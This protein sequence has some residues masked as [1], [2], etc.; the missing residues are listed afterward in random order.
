MRKLALLLAGALGATSAAITLAP[1][2]ADEG[3]TTKRITVVL[4][5]RDYKVIDLPP[6]GTSHGDVRVGNADLYDVRETRRVGSFHLFCTLTN[7]ADEPGETAELTECLYTYRLPGGEITT[8]GV[9]RRA[10]HGEVATADVDGITGGTRRFRSA[11]G[12]VHLLP[13]QG[14]KRTIVLRLVL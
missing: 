11:R 4:K 3:A 14:D 7:P 8:Q 5:N 10:S 6:A 2:R 9:N 12:D 1:A 13:S